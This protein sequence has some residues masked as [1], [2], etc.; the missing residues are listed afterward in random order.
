MAIHSTFNLDWV[1][2]G[3][4]ALYLLISGH[5]NS[6]TTWA[7][8]LPS[9]TL[10][11]LDMLW[12][13]MDL[14]LVNEAIYSWLEHFNDMLSFAAITETFL[15]L[16]IHDI[17]GET[18]MQFTIPQGANFATLSFY[19]RIVS[20]A[21]KYVTDPFLNYSPI[22]VGAIVAWNSLIQ[23]TR[24]GLRELAGYSIWELPY[25]S[26]LWLLKSN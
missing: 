13:Y 20:L 16:P 19:T 3:F 6:L 5:W 18:F 4:K 14:D 15:V 25:L 21:Y 11:V 7:S 24:G 22:M 17:T 2:L 10:F 26:I 9:L 23:Y 1:S 8:M 12:R